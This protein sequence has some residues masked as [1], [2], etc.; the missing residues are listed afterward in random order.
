[1]PQQNDAGSAIRLEVKEDGEKVDLS[2][3]ETHEVIIKKPSESKVTK[4][5]IVE[6]PYNN[7]LEAKIEDSDFDEEGM[8]LVQ[9]HIVD[10]NSSDE[11]Y[12]SKETI[13]VEENL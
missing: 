3:F 4:S 2:N 6:G 13:S 7:I 12:T 5:A 1:M 9:G 8:Y 11:Y 10:D